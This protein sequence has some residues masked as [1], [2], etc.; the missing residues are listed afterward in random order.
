[1]GKYVSRTVGPCSGWN[2]GTEVTVSD[3]KED[4]TFDGTLDSSVGDELDGTSLG[5]SDVSVGFAVGTL[6]G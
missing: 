1:V 3:G 6:V 2:E 4:G 5:L